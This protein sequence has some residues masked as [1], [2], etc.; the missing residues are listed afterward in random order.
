MPMPLSEVAGKAASRRHSY[1]P[2]TRPGA[3]TGLYP[4]LESEARARGV[5]FLGPVSQ[6]SLK[7]LYQDALALVFCSLYEGFGLPP[8]EA[9]AAGTPVVAMPFSAVPE[10][11]GDCVFYPD[12]LSS[13]A[14]AKAMELI[15]RDEA[16]RGEL[17]KNGSIRVQELQWE[18]TARKT[19]AIYRDTIL[20]PSERSLRMRRLLRDAIVHWSGNHSL[21]GCTF[22]SGT[23][24][25]LLPASI[26]I[27]QAYRALDVAV[28]TRLS[29]EIRRFRRIAARRTA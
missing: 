5:I 11:G 28:R 21:R 15:A 16:L 27:R 2:G 18:M 20:R 12:G 7:V 3:R 22:P 24:S 14:L 26:G 8:L 13:A 4:Q 23:D 10:V 9:M 6:A 29:R 25:N 17:R 19:L 1:W